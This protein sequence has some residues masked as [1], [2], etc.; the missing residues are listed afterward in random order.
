[1]KQQLQDKEPQATLQNRGSLHLE[2]YRLSFITQGLTKEEREEKR[3][4]YYRS[5]QNQIFDGKIT[6]CYVQAYKIHAKNWPCS[7]LMRVAIYDPKTVRH[8]KRPQHSVRVP[9]ILNSCL[10]FQVADW[11]HGRKAQNL[12]CRSCLKLIRMRQFGWVLDHSH[13][14]VGTHLSFH[15]W[16][17]FKHYFLCFF[18]S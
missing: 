16:R 11:F 8:F 2:N 1:M 14:S 9:P 18:L 12:A 17:S 3:V 13:Y 6:H 15:Y 5:M 10:T 4:L 7:R